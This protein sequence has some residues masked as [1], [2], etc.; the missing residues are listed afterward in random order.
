MNATSTML[1]FLHTG[2][3]TGLKFVVEHGDARCLFDFGQEHSPARALFTFGLTPRPGREVGDLIAAGA[4]PPLQGVYAGD[5]W[6]GRTH[7]FISHM[8]LDHTGLI[9]YLGP[10]VPLYY[11]AA[12][13]PLRLGADSSGYLRWRHPAGTMVADGETISVGPI[14]VRSVAVDHDLTGATGYLIE[15][16]DANIAFT[17]DHRWHGLHPELTEAFASKA[18]GAD[19]LIQEGVSLGYMP[20]AGAPPPLSEADAI[21]ALGRA[22]AEAP[23]LVIVNL[24]GMNRDRV[25]GLAAGCAAAGRRLLM[26]P[27]MAAM[28]GWPD[29]LGS[30]EPVRDDPRGHCLQLGFK[31]LP[32]LID[33]K[34]PGGSLFI[35]SGGPPDGSFDPALPVL[36]AWIARFG[37]EFRWIKSSGHSRPED[38]A[39]MVAA[40]RPKLVLPVHSAAPENLV[41]PGVPSFLPQA[42]LTYRVTDLLAG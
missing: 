13:E 4:A 22:V 17:G 15:T 34:P 37:L 24:Y 29:V 9:P 1:T 40:V 5:P 38:I 25:A 21:A 18:M 10:D 23:G 33:L 35:Q 2:N 6:D 12:M 36:E 19:L 14:R 8:H 32:L 30:I 41:V 27:E 42:G 11:P 7:V 3:P 16:P 26:E 31:S 39:R 20:L 28:A